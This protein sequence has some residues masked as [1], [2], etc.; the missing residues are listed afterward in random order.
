MSMARWPNATKRSQRYL[1]RKLRTSPLFGHDHELLPAPGGAR[2]G[3][4]H[5]SQIF[6]ARI[7]YG[8]I[9][10]DEA[11]PHARRTE[12]FERWRLAERFKAGAVGAKR[13]LVE[14]VIEIAGE[15]RT[16]ELSGN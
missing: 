7:V 5:Q 6:P 1:A 3:I 10:G 14:I 16:I 15:L 12:T 4:S 13:C 11:S 2:F 8:E 9:V